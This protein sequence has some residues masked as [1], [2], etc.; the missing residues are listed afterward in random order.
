LTVTLLAAAGCFAGSR[1]FASGDPLRYGWL[2]QS[3]GYLLL[4]TRTI[5]ALRD[6][7]AA[8]TLAVLLANVFGA[9]SPVLMVRAWYGTGLGSAIPPV[10]RRIA[11]L[12]AL[13]VALILAGP[14]TSLAAA[15]LAGN[16]TAIL[17][18]IGGVGD[19][20]SLTLFAPLLLIAVAMRGGRLAWPWGLLAGGLFCWLLCD[21]VA[22]ADGC[23]PPAILGA[24]SQ[25]LRVAACL[26]Y[27]AAGVAQREVSRPRESA[28]P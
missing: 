3:W 25:S 22:F 1:P 6:I 16:P 5:P 15:R 11:V 21:A 28:A 10:R 19:I 20:V 12:A 14:S 7:P 2:L 23:L 9:L 18:L 26:F 8:A 13:A 27:A 24:L 4:A 17:D